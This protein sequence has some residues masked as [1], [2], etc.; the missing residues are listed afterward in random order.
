[1]KKIKL[2]VGIVIMFV[3]SINSKFIFAEELDSINITVSKHYD[4]AF[5]VL[6]IVNQERTSVGLSKL[7]MSKDLMESAMLRAAESALY[8]SH[9]RPNGTSMS[10]AVD[11]SYNMLGENIA[12]G[13]TSPEHVMEGWMNSPGH[14]AKIMNA[15]FTTIGVGCYK[16]GNTYYWSQFFTR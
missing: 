12:L 11:I 10:T 16:S 3:I 2:L 4:K 5:E 9:T 14:R 1:M 8:F 6:Q 13:Y 7:T 15:N